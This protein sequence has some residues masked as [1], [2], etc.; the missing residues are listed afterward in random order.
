MILIVFFSYSQM[1]AR[2]IH[3]SIF[4][5]FFFFHTIYIKI[6]RESSL[7]AV[8]VQ[9]ERKMIVSEYLS[10]SQSMIHGETFKKHTFRFTVVHI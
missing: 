6:Y 8:T 3:K 5:F 1:N 10:Q 2:N 7:N 9:S 4:F